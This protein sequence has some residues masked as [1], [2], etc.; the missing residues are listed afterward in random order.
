MEEHLSATKQS[1]LDIEI[2]FLPHTSFRAGRMLAIAM[3]N[4]KYGDF[5]FRRFDVKIINTVLRLYRG[6]KE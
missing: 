6:G 5:G 2:A 4:E 1:N 3:T